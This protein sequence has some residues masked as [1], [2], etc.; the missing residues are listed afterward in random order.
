MDSI[1]R[2]ILPLD[3]LAPII[4]EA[5]AA[6][7]T[8]TLYPGGN[9]MLPTIRPGEDAVVLASPKEV[10]VGDVI[11][12]RRDSGVF[13]LHRI[14]GKKKDGSFVLRGDNQFYNEEGILPS[15]IIAVVAAYHKGERIVRRGS[16]REK[17]RFL[18]LRVRFG[19]RRVLLGIKRRLRGRKK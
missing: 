5:L 18:Y 14:V 2:E 10:G 12:Y 4:A 11:F 13:V 1:K 17:R 7:G 19:A 6:G 16:G 8:F 3:E 9:S 15:Q